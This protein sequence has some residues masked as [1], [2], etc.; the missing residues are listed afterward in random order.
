MPRDR[1]IGICPRSLR[2]PGLGL[3][4]AVAGPAVAAHAQPQE[5]SPAVDEAMVDSIVSVLMR[6]YDVP[7]LG[8]ALVRDR[9]VVLVKGYG[10]EGA[11]TGRPV[12]ARTV[13]STGSLSKSV[14][15]AVALRMTESG[16]LDL[17]APVTG[18]LS[19]TGTFRGFDDL[20]LRHL[21]SH[22][23]GYPPLPEWPLSTR[24][25]IVERLATVE[26]PSGPGASWAY[27]NQN[28][29]LAGYVLESVAGRPYEELAR[30]LLLDP[31][32][33][34]HQ[35]FGVA[36]L[37]SSEHA[38]PHRLDVLRGQVPVDYEGHLDPWSP[39]GGLNLSAEDL[40]RY[41]GFQLTGLD[42]EGR[43]LLSLE[44]M[45]EMHRP[46]ATALS[47]ERDAGAAIE[48]KGA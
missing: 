41:V 38:V 26:R 40:G 43:S 4:L 44:S 27:S 18:Y 19:P 16:G 42:R 1:V 11:R 25:E 9:D 12:T 5:S 47:R 10:I 39:S 46:H 8:L 20:T 6:R 21:L 45:A 33:M 17:D 48:I 35:S 22:T 24:R 13:F 31:L 3:L 15:A 14:T 28:F 30:A 23:S 7:G 2:S 37:R 29:I 32:G 36:G 34:E